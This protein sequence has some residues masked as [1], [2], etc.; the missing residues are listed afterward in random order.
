[1]F[2]TLKKYFWYIVLGIGIVAV[3][4]LFQD[5]SR[6]E[7]L[8]SLLR[9]KKVEDDVLVIK[10]AIAKKEGEVALTDEQLQQLA[11]AHQQE[12]GKATNASEDD[13]YDFY[14]KFLNK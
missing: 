5:M 10:E 2:G 4:V 11:E 6:V 14:K 1:M 8:K 9:R 7:A 13:I 3:A 12:V